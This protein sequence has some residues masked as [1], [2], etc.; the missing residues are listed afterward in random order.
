[1]STDDVTDTLS[2]SGIDY[3]DIGSTFDLTLRLKFEYCSTF[4]EAYF[5]VFVVC[6]KSDGDIT[7]DIVADAVVDWDFI[8]DSNKY[9]Y[10]W[11]SHYYCGDPSVTFTD[12]NAN[13]I[14]WFSYSRSVYDGKFYFYVSPKL[15]S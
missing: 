12:Q 2:I 11:Y 4:T 10:F 7:M 9:V 15:Y 5:K 14:A 3:N 8:E 6:D 13:S 1:M